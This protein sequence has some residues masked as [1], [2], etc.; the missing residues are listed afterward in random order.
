MTTLQSCLPW[1]HIGEDPL[2]SSSSPSEVFYYRIW[3]L[4][5]GLSIDDEETCGDDANM[6]PMEED[7]AEESKMEEID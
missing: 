1:I 5:L 4:K 2:S 7:G 3:M 6:P